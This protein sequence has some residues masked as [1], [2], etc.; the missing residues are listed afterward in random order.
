MIGLDLC[1]I[2]WLLPVFPFTI[3]L[4]SLLISLVF[5]CCFGVIFACPFYLL[6]VQLIFDSLVT[7]HVVVQ[8]QRHRKR[9]AIAHFDAAESVV[10]Q[11][12]AVEGEGQDLGTL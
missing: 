4:P 10:V 6:V 2:L 7:L 12:E 11:R 8:V 1:L 3:L 9:D 5:L